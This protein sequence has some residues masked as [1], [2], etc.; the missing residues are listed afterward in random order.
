LEELLL[1]ILSLELGHPADFLALALQ[2]P[3][4]ASITTA[5]KTLVDIEAVRKEKR[6]DGQGQQRVH[7]I[8]T[9]LG[10][11]L[12]YLPVDVRIGKMLVV[13]AILGC[14]EPILTVAACLSYK[15][16]FVSPFGMQQVSGRRRGGL[17]RG[18]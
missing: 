17:R 13:G 16:P 5:L 1:M 6:V 3:L 8:L 10:Y 7:Y 4:S 2:P 11:H 18:A 15:S 12:A 14:L 9:P